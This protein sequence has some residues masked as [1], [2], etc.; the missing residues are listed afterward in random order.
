MRQ[1]FLAK[2]SNDDDE[3]TTTTTTTRRR[4]RRRRRRGDDDDDG[5]DDDAK[6]NETNDANTAKTGAKTVQKQSETVRTC[7]E[8][9]AKTVDRKRHRTEAFE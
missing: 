1:K 8:N 9:G 4:R 3:T 7:P 5:D 6:K 2:V